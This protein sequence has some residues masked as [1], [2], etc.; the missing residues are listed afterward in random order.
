MIE[1]WLRTKAVSSDRARGKTQETTGHQPH[2]DP[3][4][5]DRAADA[6]NHLY[7]YEQGETDMA[8]K[9]SPKGSHD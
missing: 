4:A 1:R 6:G 9:D 5:G 7:A 2:L 8:S 3:Q